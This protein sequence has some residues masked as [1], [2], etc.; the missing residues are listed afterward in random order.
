RRGQRLFSGDDDVFSWAAA[1]TGRGFGVFRELRLVH[2]ISADRL[3][4]RYFL[5][6]VHDH[7]HSHAFLNYL[8]AGEEQHGIG[9]RSVIRMLLH[10]VR[11]GVFSMRCQWAAARGTASAAHILSKKALHPIWKR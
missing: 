1:D 4:Q 8:L 2:L 11:R 6:L 5:R 3:T 10:G 9:V 7:A